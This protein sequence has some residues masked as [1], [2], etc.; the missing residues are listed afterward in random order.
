MLPA[1]K[2]VIFSRRQFCQP[3]Y[4]IDMIAALCRASKMK[5]MTWRVG[6]V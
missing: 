2:T 4:R 6:K 3:P 1:K 5:T